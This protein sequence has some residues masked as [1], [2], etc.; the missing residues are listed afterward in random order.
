MT[1][2]F[3][4]AI[5]TDTGLQHLMHV[6]F[7]FPPLTSFEQQ[8]TASPLKLL[9]YRN[10]IQ[11]T[12]LKN[13]LQNSWC[14][15]LFWSVKSAVIRRGKSKTVTL[16]FSPNLCLALLLYPQFN[17]YTWHELQVLQHQGIWKYN[18]YT[19]FTNIFGKTYG[20]K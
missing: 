2:P 15:C 7:H 13:L 18:W 12:T 19:I 5:N 1:I 16:K 4:N 20:I 10:S 8:D 11:Q 6:N 3:H 17:H 14:F 9:L